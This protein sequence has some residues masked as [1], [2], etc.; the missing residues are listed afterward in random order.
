M[1]PVHGRIIVRV[2]PSQKDE[3]LW[4]DMLVK[5]TPLFETNYREKSPVVAEVIEGN[6]HLRKG[7][8]VV[9][10]HNHF[11][12]HSPYYLYDDL[13][14]IPF[15]KT[16]FA[17]FDSD[18]NMSPVCGN[19]ICEYVYAES[20]FI[21]PEEERK[22][23]ISQY[24]VIDPGWTIYKEGQTIFTRP[25]AGYMIVYHWNR[26]ERRAVKVDSGQICGVLL[27]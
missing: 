9:C 6:E 21:L 4:G 15:N 14:S 27:S 13:Y 17:K 5:M 25:H 26:Q 18:G 3:M 22:P 11:Q 12:E 7:D 10:H 1:K 20:E 23:L 19:L 16:I 2:N 8:I 24:Q